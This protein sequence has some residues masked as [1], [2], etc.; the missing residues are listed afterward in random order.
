M[1]YIASI[2]IKKNPQFQ[3]NG[4]LIDALSQITQM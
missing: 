4:M 2:T 3:A 1:V